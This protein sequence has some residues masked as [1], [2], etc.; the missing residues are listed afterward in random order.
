MDGRQIPQPRGK[1]LGGS[2]AINFGVIVHPSKANFNA[3]SALGNDG[4]NADGLAPYYRKSQTFT[5]AVGETKELLAI[6]YH[7]ET[8]HGTDGPLPVT[9]PDVYSPFNS[10]WMETFGKLG[11]TNT[12]DP[13]NGE[14]IGA[15]HTGI[16]VDPK[17][18]TRGYAAPAYYSAEVAKRPNL[19]VL[20]ETHVEK[21]LLSKDADGSVV[22]TGVR[23]RTKDGEKHD[24]SAKKEVI[25]AAGALQSPQ[26][27]ELSG[28]GQ[29]ELLQK[30]NI[31]VVIDSPGVGENL[32]DHAICAPCFEVADGQISGG[33]KSGGRGEVGCIC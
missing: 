22:A 17:T 29:K 11:W 26:V 6:D 28:I 1:L 12:D 18:K 7:D 2:S 20:V 27:L 9:H 3:W 19:Q 30:H 13:V 15:F 25:L 21:V 33:K 16:A 23:V 32:Q 24:I 5:P 31:P 4:W 8:A 10:A 14:K